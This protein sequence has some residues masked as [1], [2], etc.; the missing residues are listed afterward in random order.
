[1]KASEIFPDPKERQQVKKI[2]DFFEGTIV[3]VVDENE[4]VL[5]DI[6]KRC[7]KYLSVKK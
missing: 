6:D 4:N 1:M 7:T 5:F 2:V 3:N